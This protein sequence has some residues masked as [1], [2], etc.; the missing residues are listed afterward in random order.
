[1]NRQPAAEI[2]FVRFN[3]EHLFGIAC[4]TAVNE[5]Y[6]IRHR[7]QSTVDMCRVS[8]RIA[9]HV[10]AMYDLRC[11]EGEANN[12]L[13]LKCREKYR[14]PFGCS[15]AEAPYP[16]RPENAYKKKRSTA[17]VRA[18][19]AARSSGQILSA[20]VLLSAADGDSIN[21][22]RQDLQMDYRNYAVDLLKRKTQLEAA[23]ESLGFEIE[24]LENQKYSVSSA[25][26][27]AAPV[28]GGGGN[29]F[30]NKLVNLIV[31]IDDARF[32]R[33]IVERELKM[34]KTGFSALT[35]YQRELLELHY[36]SAVPS[37]TVAAM[38]KFYKERSQ[39]Y[40][41]KKKALEAFTRAVYGVVFI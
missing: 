17:K 34:I 4:K 25:T 33:K 6:L 15:G 32:R 19:A 11:A 38:E 23:Y 31:L 24:M 30:E 2:L 12:Q 10:A 9:R 20:A 40:D 1:M 37:P 22:E 18:K 39:I 14:I 3:I 29:H 36:V 8:G 27:S 7:C 16:G 13:F 5:T 28:T 21:S 26:V 35:D 41:D